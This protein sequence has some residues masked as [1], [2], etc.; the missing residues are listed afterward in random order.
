[1]LRTK[2]FHCG[3]AWK[4]TNTFRTLRGGALISI[5]VMISC[6]SHLTFG[7]AQ[8]SRRLAVSRTAAITGAATA[9]ISPQHAPEQ[10]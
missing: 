6:I 2:G 7:L 8:L 4:S 9:A 5:V 10:Y 3:C 1:M